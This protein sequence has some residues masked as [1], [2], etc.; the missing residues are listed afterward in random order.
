MHL[1]ILLLDRHLGFNPENGVTPHSILGTSDDY[2]K[3]QAVQKRIFE[4]YELLSKSGAPG[5]T[6]NAP[7]ISPSTYD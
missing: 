7:D 2:D 3:I 5:F 4:Q 6:K 1:N